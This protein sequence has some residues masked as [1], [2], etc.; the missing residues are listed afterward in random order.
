MKSKRFNLSKVLLTFMFMMLSAVVLVA[1]GDT[2]QDLVDQAL[3]TI[4][5]TYSSG[6]TQDSVTKNLILPETIG[7]I[8]VSWASGNT[9]VISNAGVVTRPAV[10]TEVV[11]TATLTLGDV[12]ETYSVTVTV[13]AAVVVIDPLDALDAI[14]ITGTT[15]EMVG[16]VYETTTDIVLPATALGLNITWT[17]SNATYVAINGSVTRPNFGIADQ[18]VTLTATIGGEEATFLIKVLAF[19]EKPVSQILD[20]AKTALY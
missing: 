10:D 20:E 3:E 15:L 13:I 12:S 9:A 16:S 19:T 4:A 7:E 5:V 18:V 17:T 14:V 1:C 8:S 2:D 6:D 11:L